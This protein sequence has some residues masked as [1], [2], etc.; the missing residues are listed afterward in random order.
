MKTI[1]GL[2][3]G[4][5]SVGWALIKQ[6]FEEKEGKVIGLGSRILPMSQDILGDFEKGNSISQTAERT[7]L[8]GVRRLRERHLLRRER[9]HRVLHILKFL[10]PH[11][12]ANIDFEKRIGK[13]LPDTE[14]K[15]VYDENGQFI[16]KKSFEEMLA[17]FKKHQ[18]ELLNKKNKN[19]AN[20]K[21][22]YDW[23]IYYL[24]KKA[25]TQKIESEELA[26]LLLHFNQK[27]GYYQLRGEETD[28]KPNKS[29]KFYSLKITDVV[30][31][32]PQKGKT[33]VWYNVILENSWIYRR[34]SKFPLFDWKDKVRDFIVT[35]DIDEDGNVKKDKDGKEKRSF[36]S[37]KEDDWQLLKKKTE[38]DIDKS[39]KTVG[40][41]IY[42]TLL[43]NPNQKI[44]G[45]LVRTIEREFYK[46]ELSLILEKQIQLN[47]D[48]QNKELHKQCIE[49]LYPH[50][51]NHQTVLETKDFSHLFIEDI[52]FYQR[53]LRSQKHSISNCP[54]ESRI[55]IHEGVK[56]VQPLKCI[57]RSHPLFQEFRLWQWIMNL[58]LINR[59]TDMDVTQEYLKT[60]FNIAALYTFLNEKKD[61]EQKI[62]LKYFKLKE[63]DFRWNYVED[64]KY[65]C[66]ETRALI[67][68]RLEKIINMDDS[69]TKEKEENLWHIIYSVT[70]K[71]DYEK[72]LK[73]FAHKNQ[74][75]VDSFFEAF[76]KFPPFPSSYGSYS[77]KAIKKLLP[78]I[79]MEKFWQQENIDA[80]TKS[81][82]EKIINAEYDETIK[83]KIRDKAIHLTSLE[84]FQ[85]LP[86]WLAK[87]IVYGH[88]SEKSELSKWKRVED[89]VDYIKTFKQHSLKNPI[90]EQVV[91]ETLQTIKDIWLHYGKGKENFFDEIHIELGRD[92]KN[93][94]S[95]REQMS[96][97]SIANQNTNLR[98]KALLND[99]LND[100]N[101]ENVRPFSP[102]QQDILK[103]YEE[104][105]LNSDIEIP[106]DIE[107]ISK[108]DLPTGSELQRYK[109][110]L[111]QK[112][113]SPYTGKIIPLNNLFTP[114]YEIEHI[115]PQS[116]YFD[117]SFNNKVIC[118]AAVNILKGNQTGLQFIQNHHGQIVELG[119]GKSVLIFTEEQYMDFVKQHYAKN[120]GKKTKL[121][122]LDL[123]EKMIERQLNDTRYI[124]KFIM[125]ILSNIVR[126]ETD[127]DGMNSKN[128]L[129]SNG[130][131]T[132][133]LK[134]D[135]G[136]DAIWNDL[137]LPRF[138]RLN[139]ITNTTHFTAYNERFQKY[140]P[141][142]PLEL[143]KGYQKKRIDHRHH[144]MD[145]LVIACA[146]RSHINYLNNQNA[147][148]RN[149]NPEQKSKSRYDL[150]VVLC[151][152]KFN[153]QSS[154]NYSWVFK[155]PWQNFTEESKTQLEMIVVS[156]KQNLRIINKTTNYYEK[157]K[158][159]KKQ[160]EKQ[161]KGDSWAVR[162]PMHKDTVSGLVT[163]R[164]TKL[165]SLNTAVEMPKNII[166][167]AFRNTVQ[168]LINQGYDKKKLIKHFKDNNYIS[169]NENVERVEVYYWDDTNV[170]SR[171]HLDT[172]FDK[173]KIACITDTGIQKILFKH[174]DNNHN[175]NEQAFSPEG[176]DEMNKNIVIL[177]DGKFHAPILK[178][179]TYETKGNKF[180]VGYS[181]NKKSKFV[182]AAKG[183]NLFF[184][185]YKD[186]NNKRF[187]ETIP[188][189]IV[190]ERQKQG[191]LS[192]PE[193]NEAGNKLLFFLSPN[194][195]VYLP[196]ENNTE[197]KIS[198][199]IDRNNIYKMISSSTSQCFFIK[200]SVAISIIN[201][202]EFTSL[203]KME[204]SLEG[205]MIKEN[206]VK[207]I[208]NRLG[209]YKETL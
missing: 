26:W 109:L 88:H 106:E 112:Y 24:R 50:N 72:A 140:L 45:K 148:D 17:D 147:L 91:M 52:L 43:K 46:T 114:A 165:V 169:E 111:E 90:V 176:I 188:L 37:P 74:I 66:N 107:K 200:H 86:E 170:A 25:L 14:T 68:G 77:F 150:K 40:E 5:N 75:D 179:R 202:I 186:E 184:A 21:V 137:V 161:I 144:A 180:P 166:N 101:I 16:F 78:L 49:N 67:K 104:G 44:K 174:L 39:K 132:S 48:L 113:R 102:M 158:N 164:R 133:M 193:I 145:A 122:S 175:K 136:M 81:R 108:K 204:R 12:S 120:R 116:R 59:D 63:N 171:V 64:K 41:F 51:V 183:T 125:G 80:K 152:K 20:A 84:H 146:T 73:T 31:D 28:D 189:N 36:R 190:I 15:F 177:N 22:P 8:R 205:M 97:T 143:Q 149:K 69:F 47:K 163:F 124:S 187:Y 135:W 185:I 160:I 207:L 201:K 130:Q 30:A 121:L 156:F 168:L 182:E 55:F 134:R 178:V 57:P 192:V 103:I 1:L 34:A 18:P 154:E 127:D 35:T 9:L 129:T 82:I 13:F 38:T 195:L 208:V 157:K 194:D 126:S 87:Y 191:L 32:E 54:L 33:E 42:N 99:M 199:T 93:P 142:V 98:I 58:R 119:M 85:G 173:I 3:L 7:R 139:Q 53:P 198:N 4:T 56:K 96:K 128:I 118:E 138:K 167:K 65:P 92:M 71:T 123:P 89:L 117:D 60:S 155:K 209:L 62:L 206:C 196:S 29:E 141:A 61:I 94:K 162:K 11:Y 83:E 131:A 181:G 197:K 159:G 10:P 110:W 76:K 79:R 203:N 95:V 6:N 23:T 19:G 2:D 153:D 151:D 115:I 105:V 172:S 100:N 70:D 27:R